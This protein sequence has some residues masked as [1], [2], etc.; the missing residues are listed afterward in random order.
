MKHHLYAVAWVLPGEI[1][2][3]EICAHLFRGL[4]I[5]TGDFKVRVIARFDRFERAQGLVCGGKVGEVT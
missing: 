2:A 3:M 5:L 4:S 1:N